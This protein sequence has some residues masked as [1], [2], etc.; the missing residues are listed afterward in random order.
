MFL[1]LNEKLF[2]AIIS[3]NHPIEETSYTF[4]VD[5]LQ[6]FM[7]YNLDVLRGCDE[8]YIYEFTRNASQIDNAPLDWMSFENFE[9]SRIIEKAKEYGIGYKRWLNE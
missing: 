5:D 3:H 9:H 4:S 7:H 2:G 6:L 8:K 1:L